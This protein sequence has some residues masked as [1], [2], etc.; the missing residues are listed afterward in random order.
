MAVTAL[1]GLSIGG[2]TWVSLFM[3]G[4]ITLGGV[5][6]PI[7]NE[8][9]HDEAAKVAYFDGDRQTLHDRLS[10]MAIE[11]DIKDYYRSRFDDEDELDRYIHQ[12][13]FDRTGYAGEAYKVD[14]YGRLF[15]QGY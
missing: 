14:N 1:V 7:L 6:Y 13:M 4:R 8:F 2:V 12:I 9:W 10:E 5:P 3:S 15:W 11:E